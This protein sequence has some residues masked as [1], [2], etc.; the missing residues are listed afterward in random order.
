MNWSIPAKTFLVG[1]YAALSGA[2]A[3]ILTTAPCFKLAA[4]NNIEETVIH[5]ESPAGRWWRSF[6]ERS[7]HLSWFDPYRGLGGLGASSAQFVGAYLASCSIEKKTPST[8]DMLEVYYQCAWQGQGLRPSGY[9]VLAQASHACVYINKQ[10]ETIECYDWVFEDISFLLVHTGKKL[11]THHHLQAVELPDVVRPL[12]AIADEAKLALEE[13]DSQRMV[14]AVNAYYQRLS[15]FNLM[16]DHSIKMLKVLQSQV[17]ILA[18]KG[19][20]AMGAD[21]LLLIIENKEKSEIIKQL[22]A[23]GWNILANEEN[24]HRGNALVKNNPQKRLE[25]LS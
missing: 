14:Y 21:V 5:P 7:L 24:L 11:A 18:A 25:I 19:C 22:A 2:S 16:A 23:N 9:D 4:V 17:N 3:V 1:E 13:A 12:S 15:N 6:A 20:G 10:Q 8:A